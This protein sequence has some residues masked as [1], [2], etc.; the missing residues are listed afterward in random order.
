LK[1]SL[2]NP[3]PQTQMSHHT[4]FTLGALSI[5]GGT[6]GFLKKQSKPSLVGGLFIGSLFLSSGYLISKNKDNGIELALGTSC[7]LTSVMMR[8][9]IKTRQAMPVGMCLL[10]IV[11]ASYY[12]FKLHQQVNGV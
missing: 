1:N 9:A 10:G 4:A 8:R 7:L 5:A 3:N 2:E 11:G 6:F 12:G